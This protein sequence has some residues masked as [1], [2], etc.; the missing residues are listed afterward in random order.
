MSTTKKGK[1]EKPEKVFREERRRARGGKGK[2]KLPPKTWKKEA[3]ST[4]A[5][6]SRSKDPPSDSPAELLKEGGGHGTNI[7][8][9]IMEDPPAGSDLVVPGLTSKLTQQ[10]V[11]SATSL[12]YAALGL[13]LR[14]IKNGW[15]PR[16]ADN[17]N[18]PY[19]AWR[20]LIDTMTNACGGTVDTVT[21]APKWWWEFLY[22]LKPKDGTFKTG[23]INYN[24]STGDASNPLSSVFVLGPV[25]GPE[26]IS[27]IF[28]TLDGGDVNGF[29]TIQPTPAYDPAVGPI[30]VASMWSTFSNSPYSTLMTDP[31]EKGLWLRN[32]T[33][34]FAAVYAE[35]GTSYDSPCGMAL[36]LQS[37]RFISSP[38]L[39]KFCVYQD[40]FGS[41]Q[42]RGFHEYRHNAGSA[43]YIL[44]RM[45]E[46][47]NM[48]QVH[49]KVSPVVKFFNFDEYFTQIVSALTAAQYNYFL[50]TGVSM[51]PYPLTVQGFSLML[52]QVLLPF[53]CN[54]MAQDLRLSST[55]SIQQATFLPFSVGMNGYALV[56][57][58]QPLF[59]Q[60][61]VESV[62]ACRRILADI[63]SP[64]GDKTGTIDIIPILGAYQASAGR[65]QWTVNGVNFF[66]EPD[67]EVPIDIWSCTAVDG[68]TTLY[69]DLNGQTMSAMVT[70]HN[71]WISQLTAVLTG[72]S[73]LGAEKGIS[74][75][76][77]ADTTTFTEFVSA[78][79]VEVT[80]KVGNPAMKLTSDGKGGIVKVEKVVAPEPKKNPAS[81]VGP[82]PSTTITTTTKR[83]KVVLT[84]KS[85]KEPRS[86]GKR[87]KAS[88]LSIGGV[89]VTDPYTRLQGMT[90]YLGNQ[91]MLAATW[92]YKQLIVSPIFW[93][94][95]EAFDGS[96]A[97]YQ[98]QQMEPF[99]LPVSS[100]PLYQSTPDAFTTIF[101]KN[102]R[103]GLL[104]VKSSKSDSQTEMQID[105]NALSELG[106]GGFF[107]DIAQGLAKTIGEL[108]G[109]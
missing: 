70:Q 60:F 52:R 14:A 12:A 73:T 84:R 79:V 2:V 105:M 91:P 74:A 26:T 3:V 68:P 97:E 64:K 33:S 94:G 92:K 103:A 85:S 7:D 90:H 61:F 83:G 19:A 47:K 80:T 67:G 76:T 16:C 69:V 109:W 65:G 31:G 62:R 41:Q 23:M 8:A 30:A 22:A 24:L 98:V 58:T 43:C 25:A 87:I 101:D 13:V 100:F 55:T 72:L 37:E 20:F 51:D 50:E 1:K 18:Y 95:T 106:R 99:S 63:M 78:G 82:S 48:S 42:Y 6:A 21:A 75:L 102:F 56:S 39:A 4:S 27:V 5:V 107:T 34:A 40:T 66:Q 32:D 59:P 46:F 71:L 54:E 45:S 93:V 89:P 86:I 10:V 17:P 9:K 35:L 104:D 11:I 53:F 96:I 44:P 36:T 38:I 15:L 108:T 57:G 49:N 28:G 81:P 88:T 29:P 77:I